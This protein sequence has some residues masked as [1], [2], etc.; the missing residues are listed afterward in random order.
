MNRTLSFAAMLML[1]APLF[2]ADPKPLSNPTQQ[3]AQGDSPLVAAAKRTGRLGKKPAFVI[4]NDNL[5]TTGGHFTTTASPYAITP[6]TVQGIQVPATAT[7]QPAK[8]S[9]E[10][11]RQKLT[12][13][14]Q[15][16]Y[17]GASLNGG[18]QDPAAIE[19]HLQVMQTEKLQAAKPEQLGTM[20]PTTVQTSGTQQIPTSGT[21]PISTTGAQQI[22]TATVAQPATYTN[23][24]QQ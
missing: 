10:T 17:E 24:N 9:A 2:A 16:Q 14:L 13:E 12:R 18:Y 11:E 4:T 19:H 21:Q 1:A 8:K 20:Q 5:V 3:P 23:P 22:P 6:G 15:M 7:P